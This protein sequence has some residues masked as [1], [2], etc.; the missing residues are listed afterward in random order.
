MSEITIEQGQ[1]KSY[2]LRHS[3]SQLTIVPER[4]G[5][6]TSWQVGQDEIF[7]LDR[8]RFRDRNLSVRGG[9]P[10]LFPICGN[11][12]DDTYSLNGKEY[13]L[14]QH[15][16]ARDIP[17]EVTEQSTDGKA[18]I[19]LSLKSNAE[20]RAVYPFDFELNFTYILRDDSLELIYR[21]SNLSSEPM[22]FAT[23]IHPYFW[24]NDKS[25]LEFDLP[26]NQYKIKAEPQIHQFSGKFDF[27]EE[28]ID[29]AF[30]NLF[31]NSAKVIDRDRNLKLT[32]S[33]DSE[34]STLVFWTLKGKNY[35]CLEPWTAPR[36]ALNTGESILICE[37]NQT[38]TTN[39][40]IAV[41]SL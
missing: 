6:T 9:I 14:K 33:Y 38:V 15:G 2:I 29:W 25:Q 17:W 32:L 7:Y 40:S 4:G 16:F 8:E 28:E 24:V 27:T 22:P 35:Y 12:P 36:N 1:F 11:L 26:S 18:S 23:G 37:P 19:T 21:H 41:E 30:I 13:H 5:L 20:S 39:I 3:Q 34:Y 31:D 10:L